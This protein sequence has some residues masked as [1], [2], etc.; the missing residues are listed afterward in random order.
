M[1]KVVRKFHSFEEADQ[2]DR[3]YYRSL[4][5]QEWL[6]ILLDLIAQTRESLDEEGQR[7]HRE[8]RII[9]L[10]EDTA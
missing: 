6:D 9:R 1:E 7:F 5:P 2:P 8:W 4:T 3:E 10:G